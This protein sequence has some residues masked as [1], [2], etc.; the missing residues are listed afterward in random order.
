MFTFDLEVYYKLRIIRAY[1]GKFTCIEII[2]FA[3]RTR[4]SWLL[5]SGGRRTREARNFEIRIQYRYVPQDREQ[6]LRF[7]VLEYSKYPS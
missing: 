3:R 2:F 7:S 1:V 6:F 5:K 4:F